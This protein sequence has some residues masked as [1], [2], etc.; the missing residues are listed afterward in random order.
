MGVSAKV[1]KLLR[2]LPSVSA[3]LESEEVQHWLAELPRKIVV[4]AVQEAIAQCRGQVLN[5]GVTE[6]VDLHHVLAMAEADLVRRSIPS[7]R[8]V[9]NATGIALHTGLG[10]APLCEAAIDAL[11]DGAHGYCSLEFDLV[12]GTR[13]K[14]NAHLSDL[15]TMLTG[16]E[17]GTVVN[18][19]AA[20]TLMILNTF[21]AEREVVVSR[22]ELVEIGGSFR[23]PDILRAS[24]ARLREVGTTNRT[25]IGDY[26][27]A[28]CDETAILLRV[29]PSNYRVVGFTESASMADI[30]SLA[31]RFGLLAVDDLGSGALLDM[32][33][34]G[35]PDEP[36]VRDSID[37][38]ADLVCFSGDKLV[39]GPQAGIIVG[40]K[41]YID[42][43]ES[44]PL[45]RTYRVGK[46]T[47]LALDATLR[48][49]L[50]PA[51]A[52]EE[53]P[54][55]AMLQ[56]PTDVLVQRARKLTAMLK[57]ALPEANIY[58]GSDVAYA[59]GGAMPGK[60]LET[61]IVQW[62]P[63]HAGVNE[64]VSALR[65]AET[66]VVARVRDDALCFDVRTIPESDFDT[67][68]DSITA[69]ALDTE[70]DEPGGIR[71]PIL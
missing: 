34:H 27:A 71:L 24:R 29:H 64:V 47:L 22:G 2:S 65:A 55:L 70:P 37:A 16:A 11:V 40:K 62:H 57:E 13:G 30:A 59:G 14:R 43:I 15:L 3:L 18:N 23:I 33:A 53:V 51:I 7:L 66:P 25:R 69:A 38:G 49:Y 26:E 35:L 8:R 41:T 50:D 48:Q 58:E 31:H 36:C 12:T 6:A 67:L 52:I 42:R 10:R 44:S 61:I 17:A 4:A 56:V 63:E 32:K 60:E 39:G 21:A 28:I 5:G 9:I 45:M 20:A 54:S 46:L 68:V 1:E 19:N